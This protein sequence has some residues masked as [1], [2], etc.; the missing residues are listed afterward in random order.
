MINGNQYDWESITIEGPHGV[1]IGVTE[2]AYND[3]RPAEPR[4]GKGSTPRGYGRKNYKAAGSMTLDRDEAERLRL[5]LGGSWYDGDPFPVVIAYANA[6]QP[7]VTDVL[8]D[9]KVVKADTS[10]KQGDDNVGAVKFDLNVLS[11][12]RWGGAAAVDE[13]GG[14]G[15]DGV[16]VEITV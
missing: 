6:D 3:E 16:E 15:S 4:Y 11:P 7:T 9:C 8:P 1:L 14:A 13:T 12:I 10:G 2:I 5:A